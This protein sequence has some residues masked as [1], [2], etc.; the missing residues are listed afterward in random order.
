MSLTQVRFRPPRSAAGAREGAA[1]AVLVLLGAS[2]RWGPA[3]A[4]PAS[5]GHHP[6]AGAPPD[7]S[8]VWELSHTENQ[9]AFM[10]ALGYSRFMAQA[11]LLTRVTQIVEAA[12]DDLLFTF[13]VLPRIPAST[14]RALEFVAAQVGVQFLPRRSVLVQMGRKSTP[15]HDDAGRPVLLLNPRFEGSVLKTGGLYMD[16]GHELTVDRY[17]EDD[18]MVEHARYPA[19]GVEMRRVFRKVDARSRDSDSCTA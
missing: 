8:G 9:R 18:C 1:L 10:M 16:Q 15:M 13:C 17:M 11:S 4:T 5:S 12:G 6:T 19:K 2:A 14:Q 7:F 3:R